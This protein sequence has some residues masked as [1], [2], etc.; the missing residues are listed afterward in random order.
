VAILPFTGALRASNAATLRPVVR[1]M[2][3]AYVA[4]AF[5][6]AIGLLLGWLYLRLLKVIGA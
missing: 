5:W 3:R 1:Q 4:F 2:L 6:L